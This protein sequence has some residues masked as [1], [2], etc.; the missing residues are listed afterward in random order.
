MLTGLTPLLS[1]T[2]EFVGSLPEFDSMDGSPDRPD[3]FGYARDAAIQSFRNRLGRD[4]SAIELQDWMPSYLTGADRAIYERERAMRRPY[5]ARGIPTPPRFAPRAAPAVPPPAPPPGQVSRGIGEEQ[6]NAD[7]IHPYFEAF[8]KTLQF[9]FLA[10]NL[11]LDVAVEALSP[12][13]GRRKQVRDFLSVRRL[14]KTA[15]DALMKQVEA[16]DHYKSDRERSYQTYTKK[17]LDPGP[18]RYS[19]KISPELPCYYAGSTGGAV[20]PWKHVEQR[21]A[22][23]YPMR[24]YDSAQLECSTR[25]WVAARARE[26]QLIDHFRFL[27][28]SD[29]L[30]NAIADHMWRP[31]MM[32][33]A[34]RECGHLPLPV[35]EPFAGPGM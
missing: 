30:I 2:A 3:R 11:P 5:L 27:G 20:E 22:A 9:G 18:C 32:K 4:P 25:S 31:A 33:L 26:Q 17:R 13:D 7:G 8:L 12:H 19:Q 35:P 10:R 23:D 28:L 34:E 6:P 14:D 29:N 16:Y 1:R 21:D 15:E 24:S